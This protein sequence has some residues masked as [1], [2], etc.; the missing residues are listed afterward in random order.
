MYEKSGKKF[1]Q[2]SKNKPMAKNDKNKTLIK[3]AEIDKTNKSTID[4]DYLNIN[5]S[6]YL[7]LN[8]V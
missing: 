7:V 5:S 8:S 2:D 4:L 3:K 1:M 6:T